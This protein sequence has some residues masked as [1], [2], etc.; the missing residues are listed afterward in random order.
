[1]TLCPHNA[2]RKWE[3][4]DAVKLEDAETVPTAGCREPGV[5]S[6]SWCGSTLSSSCL[7][8]TSPRGVAPPIHQHVPITSSTDYICARADV[9]R[10]TDLSPD[11][12]DGLTRVDRPVTRAHVLEGAPDN[13]GRT[14]GQGHAQIRSDRCR[15]STGFNNSTFGRAK[16]C[17]QQVRTK[18]AD[19]QCRPDAGTRRDPGPHAAPLVHRFALSE[20]LVQR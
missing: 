17:E 18:V 11:A 7:L 15:L 3:R 4:Q 20:A 6:S 13:R 9:C 1:M 8:V 12:C 5:V 14:L 19:R 16:I 10:S 2:L